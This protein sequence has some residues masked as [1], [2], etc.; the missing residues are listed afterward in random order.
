VFDILEIKEVIPEF[1]L[2]DAG[3]GLV[4]IVGE[5]ANRPDL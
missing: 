2:R 4:V 3:G 5:L 1:F